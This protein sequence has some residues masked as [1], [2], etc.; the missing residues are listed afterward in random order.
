MY[1]KYTYSSGWSCFT[2]WCASDP[3]PVLEQ[4]PQLSDEMYCP[5]TTC[6]GLV[7][8]EAPFTSVSFSRIF[9][10]FSTGFVTKPVNTLPTKSI[11]IDNAMVCIESFMSL[12]KYR[13]YIILLLS[14]QCTFL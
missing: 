3:P 14:C 10:S 8:D 6:P 5:N 13:P 2:A 11:T 4:C 1:V 9:G 7:A 12:R